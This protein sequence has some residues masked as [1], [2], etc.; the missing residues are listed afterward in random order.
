LYGQKMQLLG[1]KN[2]KKMNNDSYPL[3]KTTELES[4]AN[5]VFF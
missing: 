3:S 1:K 4:T 2:Y 5:V